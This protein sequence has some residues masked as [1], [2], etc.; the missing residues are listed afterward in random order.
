MTRAGLN[1]HYAS[2]F[3]NDQSWCIKYNYAKVLAIIYYWGDPENPSDCKLT[4]SGVAQPPLRTNF[5]IVSFLIHS[6]YILLGWSLKPFF[7]IHIYVDTRSRALLLLLSSWDQG[8]ILFIDATSSHTDRDELCYFCSISG[9]ESCLKEIPRTHFIS[10]VTAA[11][12]IFSEMF[13]KDQVLASLSGSIP[14]FSYWE[15][16]AFPS[17]RCSPFTKLSLL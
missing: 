3:K 14:C 15:G 6:H 17:W 12:R 16:N 8:Y 9:P 1:R 10:E 5:C 13:C 4:L 7:P 2:L 11:V